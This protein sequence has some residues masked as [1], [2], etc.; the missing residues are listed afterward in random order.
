MAL[1]LAN[2]SF[3]GSAPYYMI[4][5]EAGGIPTTT[6]IGSDPSNLLWTVDHKQGTWS[7]LYARRALLLK[8]E[9]FIGAVLMLTVADSKNQI[10]GFPNTQYTIE[11]E[12]VIHFAETTRSNLVI[13]HPRPARLA[14][15]LLPKT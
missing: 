4:A 3:Y 6:E 8:L 2:G 14:S 5:L 9:S 1:P 12:Y 11:G 7:C 10:G 13:Q 15:Q